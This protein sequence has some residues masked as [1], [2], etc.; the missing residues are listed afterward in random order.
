M[1]NITTVGQQLNSSS[2]PVSYNISYTSPITQ[3]TSCGIGIVGF[4]TFQT[5]DFS[6]NITIVNFLVNSMR[7]TAIAFD[8][9]IVT[10]LAVNYI[11]VGSPAPFIEVQFFC[12]KPYI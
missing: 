8:D 2:I 7:I 3:T 10:Y 6:I 5:N 9:T 12:N 4:K 11:A 1:V